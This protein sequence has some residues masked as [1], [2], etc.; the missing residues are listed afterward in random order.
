MPSLTVDTNGWIP[1]GAVQ[2]PQAAHI[3]DIVANGV[4]GTR[5]LNGSNGTHVLN[6]SDGARV[7][8]GKSAANTLTGKN[9]QK[10][11]VELDD[12]PVLIVGGGPTGLL[13]AYLLSK[14]NGMSNYHML[15]ILRNLT[16]ASS[17]VPLDREISPTTFCTESACTEPSDA[18]DMS[19]IR[20]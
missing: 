5:T 8:D 4:N 3:N 15:L 7:V 1:D 9:Y 18:R 20:S 11:R 14:L 10:S 19:T 16:F 12:V 6:S 2:P 13:L 17:K